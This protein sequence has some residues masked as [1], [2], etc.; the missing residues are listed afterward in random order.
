M[1]IG[2]PPR[3]ACW[4]GWV[5]SC[6]WSLESLRTVWRLSL[7][8]IGT[9]IDAETDPSEVMKTHGDQVSMRNLL[10]QEQRLYCSGHG[11]SKRHSLLF[12]QS[13]PSFGVLEARAGHVI[14]F[15]VCWLLMWFC[16]FLFLL[17]FWCFS[18]FLTRNLYI[19]RKHDTNIFQHSLHFEVLFMHAQQSCDLRISIYFLW[20]LMFALLR[21]AFP[22]KSI[23]KFSCLL[24]QVSNIASQSL[25][26]CLGQTYSNVNIP[27]RT[28]FYYLF[29]QRVS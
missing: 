9:S 4:R 8:N 16:Q 26:C 25:I 2:Y 3:G 23:K 24:F 29:I 14:V 15:L 28:G 5:V 20:C 7:S 27:S 22:S 6:L 10:A 18:Y 17:H 19:W 12:E 1:G 11:G 21:K 13:W